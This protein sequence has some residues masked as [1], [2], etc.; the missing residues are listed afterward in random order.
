MSS[1]GVKSGYAKVSQRLP[2]SEWLRWQAALLGDMEGA[3][4][5]ADALEGGAAFKVLQALV[6]GWLQAAMQYSSAC[7]HDPTS[8]FRNTCYNHNGRVLIGHYTSV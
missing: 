4:S 7:A 5:L 2:V 8:I 1:C 3:A 6:Q